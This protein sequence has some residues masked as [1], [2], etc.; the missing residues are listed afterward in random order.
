[1]S[2][3]AVMIRAVRPLL[4]FI[5]AL[6]LI[7]LVNVALDGAL[8][9]TFGLI[10]RRLDGLDG[11]IGMPLLHGSWEHLTANTTPLLILGGLILLLARSRFVPATIICVV[12]GGVLTWLFAREHN[13]IGASGLIFGWFGFVVALGVLERSGQAILGAAVALIMYG[14]PTILGLSPLDAR[15]S[16]DGHL[17]G[18][19]AGIAAA[20]MLKRPRR[21]RRNARARAPI[22]R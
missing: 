16:W 7:H 12:L 5:A 11:V 6:W 18:L 20:W 15:V 17:A 10:P 9:E 22:R 2:K 4:A 1:M 13:H 19:V 21:S 3:I 8:A 14:L